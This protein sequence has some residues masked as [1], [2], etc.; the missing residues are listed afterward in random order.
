MIILNLGCGTKTSPL[1]INIDWSIYL[2]LKRNPIGAAVAARVL[3]GERLEHFQSL[4]PN[5]VVHDLSRGIPAD[6]NSADVVYHSHLLEHISRDQ[7]PSFLAEIRRVLK[8]RGVH[9]VVI[10]DWE[11]MCRDY[12][13]DVQACNDDHEGRDR[14]ETYI[15]AMI[16]QLVRTEAHG[17]IQQGPIQ[18][19]L[20]NLFFGDARRRGEVHRWMYDRISL[21]SILVKAGFVDVQVVDFKRSVIPNWDAIGLDR[22]KRGGEHKPGSMYVEA[23]KP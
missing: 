4:G 7:I 17:T 15:A 18:R 12:L 19:R 3:R 10:P 13:D 9:R 23:L 21:E 8:P 6:T 20:E 16:E 5:L 22:D 14:H 1:C 2:R 11:R